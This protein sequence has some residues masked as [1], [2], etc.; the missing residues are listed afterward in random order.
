MARRS[1]PWYREERKAWYV[2]H[3][4]RQVRLATDK[5][6]SYDKWHDL[7]SLSKVTT[8]G[9]K[10]SF[11]V[12]AEQFLDWINRNKK[13]KTYKVYRLHLQA[14]C[15]IH[16]D[17]ELRDL[18]AIHV[19]A[20]MKKN[21]HWGKST[22][23]GVMVCILTTLNWA[24]KQGIATRN[25]LAKK[26]DIPPIVSRGRDSVISPDDYEKLIVSANDRL[27]DFLVA[28]RNSGTRPHIVAEVTAKHFHEAAECWVMP[29][30][31]TDSDG[32]PLVIHLNTTL[33]A[34][35]RR[36]VAERPEGPL[37]VNN[38]GNRW[39]DTAWGKAMAGLRQQFQEAGETISCTGIM[40]GFRHTYATDLLEQGVPE[41]HVA[42]LLGHKSTA[43]LSKHYSHL[44]S[45]AQTLKAHLS[46]IKMMEC[47]AQ[48]EGGDTPPAFEMGERSPEPD[49]G[50]A[51]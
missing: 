24:V 27:R 51:A 22:R 40:Y 5:D 18:K 35:T 42:G 45:K 26:L 20:L 29:E 31:K 46:H 32:Q 14:F 6:E 4:G 34:L 39:T 49:E 11:K 25:P 15:D 10:N 16:G 43:M 12:V 8:A 13:P 47:E 23:R 19:D 17:V 38:K 44:S 36:L 1:E 3:E 48:V 41:T 33:L 28:C 9:D 21:P 7:M 30:H 2:W 50:T 37:F